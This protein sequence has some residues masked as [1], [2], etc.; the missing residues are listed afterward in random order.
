M[1]LD[2]PKISKGIPSTG[3]N[4]VQRKG[5]IPSGLPC[6]DT[7]VEVRCT[8]LS[9]VSLTARLLRELLLPRA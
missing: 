6:G 7:D 2:V 4:Q 8:I 1:L 5:K 9:L 3:K